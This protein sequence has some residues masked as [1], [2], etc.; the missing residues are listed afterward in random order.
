MCRIRTKGEAMPRGRAKAPTPR[1]VAARRIQEIR[2]AK[3]WSQQDLADRLGELGTPMDRATVARTEGGTRG[4]SLDDAFLFAAALG[5]RP[6]SVFFGFVYN[7][8]VQLSPKLTLPA[9]EARRWMHGQ[10][11]LRPEDFRTYYTEVPDEELAVRQHTALGQVMAGVQD[12]EA[13][14][15]DDDKERGAELI[16]HIQEWLD[17]ARS[18]LKA[19]SGRSDRRKGK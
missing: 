3:G 14:W 7:D 8:P 4:L 11:P 10:H 15:R 12:L 9:G 13:A 16:D 5:V 18:E 2:K 19:F 17:R 6:T 1:Q